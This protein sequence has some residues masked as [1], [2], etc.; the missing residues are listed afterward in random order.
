MIPLTVIL[1]V[2]LLIHLTT[3]LQST[4]PPIQKTSLSLLHRI[5]QVFATTKQQPSFRIV[6]GGVYLASVE[7]NDVVHALCRPIAHPTVTN[8]VVGSV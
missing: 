1:T 5:P 8:I 2:I 3:S 6:Q 7:Y 4:L